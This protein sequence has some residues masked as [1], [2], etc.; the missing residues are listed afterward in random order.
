MM[1][2]RVALFFRRP[3]VRLDVP[4][5]LVDRP[6]MHLGGALVRDG[7]LIVAISVAAVRLLVPLVGVLGAGVRKLDVFGGDGLAG[8]QGFRPALELLRALGRFVTRRATHAQTV[9]PFSV[10]SWVDAGRRGR[11]R[12]NGKAF[13]IADPRIVTEAEAAAHVS[14]K[15]RPIFARLPFEDAALLTKTG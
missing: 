4:E 12:R 3:P 13:G 14:P 6:L 1:A 5:V 8:G 10:K 15:A 9:D 2:G 7:G 11:M